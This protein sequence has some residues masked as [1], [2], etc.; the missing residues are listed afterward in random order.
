[1]TIEEDQAKLIKDLELVEKM[2]AGCYHGTNCLIHVGRI[3]DKA[4]SGYYHNQT[5]G[6]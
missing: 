4:R 3:A 2:I 6:D 5:K 1:M